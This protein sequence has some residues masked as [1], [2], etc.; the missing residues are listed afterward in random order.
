MVIYGELVPMLYSYQDGRLVWD[1]VLPDGI[2]KGR[3]GFGVIPQHTV[4]EDKEI[5]DR[6]NIDSPDIGGEDG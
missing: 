4:T 1:Y 6:G 3:C 5:Q 2:E